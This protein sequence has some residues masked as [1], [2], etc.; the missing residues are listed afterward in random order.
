MLKPVDERRVNLLK[1]KRELPSLVFINL[2]SRPHLIENLE[3][4]A[5]DSHGDDEEAIHNKPLRTMERG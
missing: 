1:I 3:P 4:A 5:D 2:I